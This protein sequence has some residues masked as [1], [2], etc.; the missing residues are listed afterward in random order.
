[1]KISES[2]P[3]P[4]SAILTIFVLTLMF[5]GA[6]WAGIPEKVILSFNGTSGNQPSGLTMDSAG[7]LWV[8]TVAGGAGNCSAAPPGCGTV[9]RLTPSGS[10]WSLTIIYRFQGGADGANPTG[11]LA[12]DAAGNAYGVAFGGGSP[13]C[14]CGIVFKLTPESNGYKESVIYRFAPSGS[15]HDGEA[16]YGG[17]VMDSAGNLYGVTISGGKGGLGT[18]YKLSPLSGGWIESILY[19]FMGPNEFNDGAN[20]Y[21]LPV[22]DGEGN[23]YGTTYAGGSGGC[24]GALPN[25]GTVFELSPNSSGGWTENI[26]YNFQEGAHDGSHPHAG[27]V[28]DASGNLYGTTVEGGSSTCQAGVLGC[29]TVFM[30]SPT[31]GGGWS[32]SVIH[33]F[34]EHDGQTPY[35]GLILDPTGNLYGVTNWGGIYGWGTAFELT[36]GTAGN[37]SESILHNFGNGKDGEDPFTPLVFDSAGNL[38]GAT[39]LGGAGLSDACS[40]TGCGT[41]FQLTP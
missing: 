25:C 13:A 20:P 5:T 36:P 27:L 16:P 11:K 37:W 10:G 19:N 12:F 32:E 3:I 31:S 22:F 17:L 9:A 4:L 26:L 33:Y 14:Q 35:S 29:G 21:G 28:F 15:H 41:V 7:N 18:V 40:G 23:L 2:K 38:Y 24:G 8:L 30:L 34:S 39:A 1:M 6:A